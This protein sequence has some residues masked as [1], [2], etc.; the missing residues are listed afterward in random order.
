MFSRIVLAFISIC[1]LQ[2]QSDWRFAD[3]N[4]NLVG[5]L[6]WHGVMGSP[7]G[8]SLKA[9]ILKSSAGSALSGALDVVD[10]IQLSSTAVDQDGRTAN[11]WVAALTGRFDLNAVSAQLAS[12]GYTP[13]S[14]RS[15]A[16][17]VPAKASSKAV[18]LALIDSSRILL[19]DA[20]PLRQA[21]DRVL[22]STGAQQNALFT[23]AGT[24]AAANDLWA[25]GAGSPFSLYK[26]KVPD[27]LAGLPAL[28]WYSIGLGLTGQPVLRLNLA[29][30]N[31]A[32]AAVFVQLLGLVPYV[33]KVNP[34]E[35]QVLQE[36]WA[37]SQFTQDA[38]VAQ[39][40]I[41]LDLLL[42]ALLQ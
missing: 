20:A 8:P 17:L 18:Q 35:R 2:A 16:L 21:I 38:G 40:V 34:S 5:G 41:P 24:L 36:I 23:R 6:S 31:A 19:G 42:S 15:V 33:L 9:G 13:L 4:A 1:Y 26:K 3:P 37:K 28:A 12:V 27:V 11:Q 22:D 30:V 14:Y 39:A 10:A 29:A 25:T 7:I 32:D